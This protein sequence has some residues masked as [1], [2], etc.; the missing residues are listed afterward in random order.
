MHAA[1]LSFLFAHVP[2]RSR[3][4]GLGKS[5][6]SIIRLSNKPYPLRRALAGRQRRLAHSRGLER[7][8]CKPVQ[9]G[10]SDR[11]AERPDGSGG[12]MNGRPKLGGVEERLSNRKWVSHAREGRGRKRSLA[13]TRPVVFNGLMTEFNTL[14]DILVA[15][16]RHKNAAAVA[17]QSGVASSE[18]PRDAIF[19]GLA[20]VA[21]V[22][23]VDHFNFLPSTPK[24]ER[25]SGDLTF[26]VGIQSDR[27]NVEGK[28]AAIWPHVEVFSRHFTA[29]RKR[30]SSNWIR[31][32]APFPLPA[33][34][35]QLGYL[36]EPAGWREW[37]FANADVRYSV[38][39]DLAACIRGGAYSL[40]SAFETGIEAVANLPDLDWP[41]EQIMSYLL[42][43][44]R[45]NIVNS[46]LKRFLDQRDDIRFEF[47]R[48]SSKFQRNGVPTCRKGGAHD[49]AAFAVATGYPWEL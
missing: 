36:C 37:D 8:V 23:A 16:A 1:Y 9:S 14:A 40:F 35:T 2:G 28:R 43:F 31:P 7:T 34:G 5:M 4:L 29:W 15:S 22:I 12:E 17:R 38:A 27:N 25:K 24:F 21:S 42:A 18:R 39:M 41:S 11:C 3:S 20:I 44:E 47:E 10:H 49:L 48:L 19:D 13:V 32:N 45:P 30:H 26:R 33:Y 46:K 6:A